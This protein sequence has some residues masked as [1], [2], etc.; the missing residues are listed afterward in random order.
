L[1]SAL[2]LVLCV[3]VYLKL[4]A[5]FDRT[6]RVGAPSAQAGFHP[7]SG[8]ALVGVS[9]QLTINT[10]CGL[11]SSGSPDFSGSFWDPVGPNDDGNGNPPVGVGNPIDRGTMVL[12]SPNTAQFTSQTGAKFL[13]TRH[14][15]NK[16]FAACW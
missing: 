11:A 6:L 2:A 1:L 10:H 4:S 7:H 16:T 12:L 5:D 14:I 13:F 3:V 15:G 9:Y 8:M